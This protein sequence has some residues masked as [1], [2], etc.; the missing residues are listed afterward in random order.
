MG[1]AMTKSPKV[2]TS[3]SSAGESTCEIQKPFPVKEN[4]QVATMRIVHDLGHVRIDKQRR[5]RATFHLGGR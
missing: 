3:Q 2:S 5:V 1:A 4:L